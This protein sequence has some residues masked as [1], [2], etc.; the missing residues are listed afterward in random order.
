M[1]IEQ[2]LEL[3]KK[4]VDSSMRNVKRCVVSNLNTAQIEGN[5]VSELNVIK[6]QL[7]GVL[8]GLDNDE[9]S[10][11]ICEGYIIFNKMLREDL[12]AICTKHGVPHGNPSP[13]TL[14][15]LAMYKRKL[16]KCTD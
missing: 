11:L 5:M 4:I 2:F 1:D 13:L 16:D 6:D 10:G 15:A 3:D 12:K 7:V 9:A 8:A 14:M